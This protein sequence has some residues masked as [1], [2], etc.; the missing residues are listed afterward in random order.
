MIMALQKQQVPTILLVV[1]SSVSQVRGVER[2]LTKK[3]KKEPTAPKKYPIDPETWFVGFWQGID[4]LDG[5]LFY[6][7]F[8]PADT[9]DYSNNNNFTLNGRLEYSQI[10]GSG[11][12]GDEDGPPP[13]TENVVPAQL[14][15][16]GLV[17]ETTHV[18][19]GVFD[20]VCLGE[21]EPIVQVPVDYV[22]Y[23]PDILMEV[24]AFRRDFPIYYHRLS[25]TN[26]MPF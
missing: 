22:P 10:C 15:G 12:G 2:H 19:Q 17:N 18:L 1:A 8:L 25:S 5:A 16:F 20:L 4:P 14:T 24:P 6:R 9:K 26:V 11:E 7:E 3:G 21:T 23:S 13:A